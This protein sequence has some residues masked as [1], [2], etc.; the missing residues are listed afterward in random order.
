MITDAILVPA[1]EAVVFW[2]DDV[3]RAARL[4]QDGVTLVE[5]DRH[6]TLLLSIHAERR[7]LSP[8]PLTIEELREHVRDWARRHRALT[9]L[10]S[11]MDPRLILLCHKLRGMLL[12]M[13]RRQQGHRGRRWARRTPSWTRRVAMEFDTWRSGLA[14]AAARDEALGKRR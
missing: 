12:S 5:S 1:A 10:I 3:V 9:M 13:S 6:V 7:R 14:G 4:D 2:E 8:P 11:G